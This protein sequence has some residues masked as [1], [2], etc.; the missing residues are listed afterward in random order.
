M[1]VKVVY[2]YYEYSEPDSDGLTSYTE[3]TETEDIEAKVG[4]TVSI[5]EK[6]Y[7]GNTLAMPSMD[8]D[9][10]EDTT[11]IDIYYDPI[12]TSVEFITPA[13]TQTD[14]FVYGSVI[15]SD[16]VQ[17]DL[18]GYI[19]KGWTW[20]GQDTPTMLGELI[21]ETDSITLTGVFEAGK[22]TVHFDANGG[23]GSMDDMTVEIGAK[24]RLDKNQFTREGYTFAGWS[25]SPENTGS[26]TASESTTGTG[27]AT[28]EGAGTAVSEGAGTAVSEGAGTAVS[29]GAGTAT[30][31][32]AGTASEG[33]GTASDG[34]GTAS[35]GAGTGT[36]TS[37]GGT[38]G[39]EINAEFGDAAYI[40]N[41][42]TAD[43]DVVTLYAVWIEGEPVQYT[44]EH[45]IISEDGA[46]EITTEVYYGLPF[47]N[48][49]AMPLV[50]EGYECEQGETGY[51]EEIAVDGSTV[52]TYIYHPAEA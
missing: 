27:T 47:E 50:I 15:N 16:K 8:F 30:S 46:E 42:A 20:D 35:E 17:T 32:G 1:N 48:T 23:E 2:H 3:A 52:I 10:D 18:E 21:A 6:A 19:F 31:E 28:S 33:A 25:R 12:I 51:T 4:S 9:I 13:G 37:T 34:A 38:T 22:Y 24:V 14:T 36:G 41:L 7:T 26:G 45:H 40:T 43:G 44:V 29:E 5:P 49:T 11:T 39:T